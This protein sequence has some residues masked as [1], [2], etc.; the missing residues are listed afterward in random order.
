M[1]VLDASLPP[2]GPPE[3]AAFHRSVD[4]NKVICHVFDIWLRFLL[5]FVD[6]VDLTV[7]TVLGEH[8][9]TLCE[10]RRRFGFSRPSVFVRFTSIR[11]DREREQPCHKMTFIDC[12]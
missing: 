3:G 4:Q 11:L 2:F 10:I 1:R 5:H 12:R 7:S 9:F 8:M 6:C